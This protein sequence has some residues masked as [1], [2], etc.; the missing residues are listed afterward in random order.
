MGPQLLIVADP[1]RGRDVAE[2]VRALGYDANTCAPRELNRMVRMADPPD[3]VMLSADDADPSLVLAGLRR[4][5]RGASI[6]VLVFAAMGGD[7]KDLAD[8]LDLGGDGFVPEP[9]EDDVLSQALD[10]L[11]GPPEEPQLDAPRAR[12][13]RGSSGARRA[14]PPPSFE[15]PPNPPEEEDV[16]RYESQPRDSAASSSSWRRETTDVLD[17][18]GRVRERD[19]LGDAREGKGESNAVL[20][21]LHATLDRLEARLRDDEVDEGE[22]ELD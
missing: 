22:E 10:E 9:I 3:A 8:V 16:P 2:Q 7:I 14:A 18:R 15:P 17:E 21:Q 20:G 11:V 4:S 5:R 6:P 13:R 1:D 19:F 12:E